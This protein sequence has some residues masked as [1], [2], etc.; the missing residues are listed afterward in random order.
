[1]DY[2]RSVRFKNDKKMNT[3]LHFKLLHLI[4]YLSSLLIRPHLIEQLCALLPSIFELI[5]CQV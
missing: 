1:M 2:L 3:I 4:I 5:S